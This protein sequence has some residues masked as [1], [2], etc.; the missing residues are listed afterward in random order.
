MELVSYETTN[1]K[2]VCLC[3][4][5]CL[6]YPACKS[7]LFCA[8]LCC[9]LW[10]VWL[11]RIFPHYLINGTIFGRKRCTKYKMCVLM[12]S[13]TFVWNIFH[14]K[15]KATMYYN[16]VQSS[17]C[18]LHVFL[19]RCWLKFNF[20]DGLSK[21]YQ[22]SKVMKIRPVGWELIRADKQKAGNTLFRSFNV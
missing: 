9:H 22:I 4:N 17:S 11:F 14:S 1:I 13:A 16:K 8:V 15:R 10:P 7:C 20:L 2:H 18:K 3:H 12:F 6:S 5:P 19:A 21:N